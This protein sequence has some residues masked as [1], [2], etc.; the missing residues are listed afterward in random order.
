MWTSTY[1]TWMLYT[2]IFFHCSMQW[3]FGIT[4][5]EIFSGGKTPY[6]GVDPLSLVQLLENG[7]RLDKPLNAACTDTM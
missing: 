5:W 4:C 7:R 3:S 6:P 1:H 2:G